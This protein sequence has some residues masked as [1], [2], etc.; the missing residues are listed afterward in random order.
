M[1]VGKGAVI[2][3]SL[4]QRKISRMR[5]KLSVLFQTERIGYESAL[6][7]LSQWLREQPKR[8]KRPGGIGRR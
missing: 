2:A 3:R 4:V 8:T 1:T 6:N 5:S 7:E